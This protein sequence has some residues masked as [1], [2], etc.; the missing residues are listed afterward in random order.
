VTTP[1]LAEARGWA[2]A[3]AAVQVEAG[4][5]RAQGRDSLAASFDLVVQTLAGKCGDVEVS[6]R[7]GAR[8]W[9]SEHVDEF[10]SRHAAAEFAALRGLVVVART[11]VTDVDWLVVET[12]VSD[13]E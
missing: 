13:A 1:E 4:R 6:H 5:Q 7:W 3:V 2:K 10:A 8:W 9:M 11:V 12:G